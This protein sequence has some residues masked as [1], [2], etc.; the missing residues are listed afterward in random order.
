MAEL[1]KN[2]PSNEIGDS[3][4]VLK[5]TLHISDSGAPE[6]SYPVAAIEAVVDNDRGDSVKAYAVLAKGGNVKFGD[7][8]KLEFHDGCILGRQYISPNAPSGGQNGDMWFQYEP[9]YYSVGEIALNGAAATE[10][11]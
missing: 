9:E 11:I 1:Y 2:I 8:V 7:S 10:A 4:S 6:N 3:Y 5:S